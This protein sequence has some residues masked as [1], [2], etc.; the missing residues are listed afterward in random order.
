MVQAIFLGN[1]GF[2]EKCCLL[3]KGAAFRKGGRV[4]RKGAA[5]SRKVVE[6]IGGRVIRKAAA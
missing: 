1:V 3:A 5:F 4:I 2:W 6:Y